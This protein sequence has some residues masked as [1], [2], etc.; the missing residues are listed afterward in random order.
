MKSLRIA[1]QMDPIETM[2][3]QRDTSLALMIEAQNRGHET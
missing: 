3:V 1:V 2:V